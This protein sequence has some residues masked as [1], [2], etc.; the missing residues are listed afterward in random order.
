MSIRSFETK[1]I[2]T[3]KTKLA[4]HLKFAGSFRS[5]QSIRTFSFVLV[6]AII[7]GSCSVEINT[8]NRSGTVSDDYI[9][10][11]ISEKSKKYSAALESSNKLIELIK[12]KEFQKIHG[13]F[14]DDSMKSVLTEQVLENSY[15]EAVNAMGDIVEYKQNQWGFVPTKNDDLEYVTSYKIVFH[16]KG[17]LDYSFSFK[18]EGDQSKIFRIALKPRKK[19]RM[20]NEM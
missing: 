19:A 18:L 20:P 15:T 17:R 13:S 5:V 7:L 9:E 16:E 2:G 3:T 4:K 10:E 14:V 8:A 12:K 1:R 6:T 11:P